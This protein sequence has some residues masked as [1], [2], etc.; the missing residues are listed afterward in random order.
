MT[1]GVTLVDGGAIGIALEGT[2]GSVAAKSVRGDPDE[3]VVVVDA[4]GMV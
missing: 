1:R 3:G 4:G 2:R